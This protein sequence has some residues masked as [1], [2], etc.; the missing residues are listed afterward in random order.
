MIYLTENQLA[1]VALSVFHL[2]PRRSDA[3]AFCQKCFYIFT[4]WLLCNLGTC[5]HNVKHP[6][7]V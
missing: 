5:V 4:P 6:L 1:A 7:D 2:R 3:N